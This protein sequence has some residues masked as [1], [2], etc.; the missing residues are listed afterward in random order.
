M[1]MKMK[2][3]KEKKKKKEEGKEEGKEER[4]GKMK[5]FYMKDEAFHKYN[6]EIFFI[7]NNINILN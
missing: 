6:S 5:K 3:K 2:T 7:I 1:K 4:K